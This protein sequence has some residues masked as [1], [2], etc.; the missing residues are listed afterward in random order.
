MS[1][2]PTSKWHKYFNCK[3]VW[4]KMTDRF[5]RFTV[6]LSYNVKILS[7][8]E[9]IQLKILRVVVYYKFYQLSGERI[10]CTFRWLV[11]AVCRDNYKHVILYRNSLLMRE[12]LK[13]SY[14]NVN[15][16]KCG[17][18]SGIFD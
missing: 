7:F 12:N 2:C 5:S 17:C 16:K 8:S 3:F 10:K 11:L 4:W 15:F 14:T 9:T 18:G 1:S 6:W 13:I